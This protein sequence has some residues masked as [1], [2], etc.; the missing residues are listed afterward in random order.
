M[1][2]KFAQGFY[3]MINPHKY[4]GKT[5]PYYRS[6]WENRIMIMFD[7]HEHIL[8][9]ASEPLKI[10][11]RHPI[12]GK[13]TV[14]VPDFLITYRNRSD[15]IRAELIE[16]KPLKQCMVEDKMKPHERATVAVN[17]A[18]WTMAQKFCQQNGLFFRVI[19]ESDI[20]YQG[21]KKR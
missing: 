2:R 6:G 11:Y 9:W 18:K 5:K 4:V 16:V 19:T 21:R 3:E 15:Q 1:S 12:T 14:Y 13:G 20:F 7:T 8:Q 17:H 10:P